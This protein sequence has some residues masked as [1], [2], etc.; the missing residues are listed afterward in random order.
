MAAGDSTHQRVL[1]IGAGGLGREVYQYSLDILSPS[2]YE[3]AGYLD[4]SPEAVMRQSVTLEAPIVGPIKNHVPLSDHR[5]IMAIGEPSVRAQVAESLRAS[6]AEFLTLVHPLA[7]ISANATIGY[8]CII[9]PFVTIGAGSAIQEFSHLHFYAS[10]AH[11]TNIGS[12]A[13]LSPY[14]VVNGQAV[15]ETGVFLGTHVTINPTRKVGAW[16]KVTAGSVVYRDVPAESIAAGNPA[17]SRPQLRVA[18][19]HQPH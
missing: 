1:I 11:D 13:S 6:G 2:R 7:Y 16:A 10:A 17:K 14:A 19:P 9:A 18:N 5:Y 12:Y 4:D 8:G 3:V 15:I